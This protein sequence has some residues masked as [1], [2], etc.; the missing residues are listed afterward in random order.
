MALKGDMVTLDSDIAYKC[1]IATERGVFL[2]MATTG[3]GVGYEAYVATR[4]ANPSGTVVIGCLMH[5][6]VDIDT[7]RAFL[8]RMKLETLIGRNVEIMKKG[9]VVTNMI[10]GTPTMGA[11]AYLA[12]S[13]NVSPT[14]ASGA[15]VVGQFKSTK[16]AS[17]FATLEINLPT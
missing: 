5:D 3:S 11:I 14:Q 16:D 6:V 17:G 15:P 4:S 10:I 2:T 9:R 8:N 12:A 13:G 1:N 7:N